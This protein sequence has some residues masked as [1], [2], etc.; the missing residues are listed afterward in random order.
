ERAAESAA[1]RGFVYGEAAEADHRHVVASEAF[2]RQGGR[3]AEFERGR[4]QRIE[5]EDAGRRIGRRGDE[6][7][8]AAAVMV[9]TGVAPQVEVEIGVAAIEGRA[10][11]PFGDRRFLPDDRRHGK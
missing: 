2:L 10:I 8:C 7:F 1:L 5:A 9:L 4:R 6:A 3:A 11:V